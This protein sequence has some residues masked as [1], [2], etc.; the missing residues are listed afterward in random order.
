[1]NAE[2][3]LKYTCAACL[4]ENTKGCERCEKEF[5]TFMVAYTIGL[6]AMHAMAGFHKP[7]FRK[8]EE[9]ENDT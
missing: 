4:V 1:M 5:T 3:E 8:E 7:K 2:G 9:D 6:A